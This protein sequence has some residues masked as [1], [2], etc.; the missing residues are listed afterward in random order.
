M[1]STD[2]MRTGA[3][4]RSTSSSGEDLN[5][6]IEAIRADIQSLTHTVGRIAN[7]QINR[8]QDKAMKTAAEAEEAIKRSPLSAV[9]IAVGL[10][11]LFGV[12]SRR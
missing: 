8:A 9:A 1:S 7:T 3:A 6:Q 5:E 2:N 4:K 11:F 12:F 10:G